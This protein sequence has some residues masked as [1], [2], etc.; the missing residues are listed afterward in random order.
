[1]GFCGANLQRFFG[2][3]NTCRYFFSEKHLFDYF[4]PLFDQISV[5]SLIKWQWD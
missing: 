4:A 2:L 3:C 1:M 5:T